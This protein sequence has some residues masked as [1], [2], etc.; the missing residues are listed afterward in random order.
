MK[1]Q[2]S[3]II[4]TEKLTKTTIPN[5]DQQ[6]KNI[7]DILYLQISKTQQGGDDSLKESRA[8]SALASQFLKAQSLRLSTA[9]FMVGLTDETNR[10]STIN[11]YLNS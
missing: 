5:T 9:K 2:K 10:A 8:I 3:E 11:K 7:T 4:K 1:K 6:F